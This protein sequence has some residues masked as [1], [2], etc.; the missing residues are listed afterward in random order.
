MWRHSSD[1]RR[2]SGREPR[3]PVLRQIVC[4]LKIAQFPAATAVPSRLSLHPRAPRIS[5]GRTPAQYTCIYKDGG[6]RT[7]P[8]RCLVRIRQPDRTG[9]AA[10]PVAR[11]KGRQLPTQ[12]S[13]TPFCQG[14]SNEVRIGL[15]LRDRTAAGT[16]SPY[17][18]SRSKMTNLGADPNGNASRNCWT[19]HR[20]VGCFVT[21]KCRIRR[22]S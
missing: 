11:E 9:G 5:P 22:R 4:V 8:R 2:T 20:L 10:L 12:R 14:L 13:A 6:T 15:T 19:I 3:S 18:A 17:L 1:P 7:F 16:S 21:L